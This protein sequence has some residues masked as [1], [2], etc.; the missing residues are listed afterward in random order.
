MG[1]IEVAE[2]QERER[3]SYIYDLVCPHCDEHTDWVLTPSA[4]QDRL[5]ALNSKPGKQ[6]D[7]LVTRGSHKPC[8]KEIW[9]IYSE[10]ADKKLTCGLGDGPTD[11]SSLGYA[12]RQGE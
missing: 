9:L 4:Y 3:P 12:R 7:G 8:G 2:Q 6:A 5:A 11:H 10:S 1:F